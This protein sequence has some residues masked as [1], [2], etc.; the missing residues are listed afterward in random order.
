MVLRGQRV[1]DPV[2]APGALEREATAGTA[3]YVKNA[4]A[5]LVNYERFGR[6]VLAE[7]LRA[8]R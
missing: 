1:G 3:R 7:E 8:S 5:S 2:Q 6:R 4:A